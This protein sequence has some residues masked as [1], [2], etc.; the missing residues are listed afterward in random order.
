MKITVDI[1]SRLSD[2]SLQQ[3]QKYIELIETNKDNAEGENL[4]HF[5]ALKTLEIFCNIPYKT[6]MMLKVRDVNAAIY[7]ITEILA[8]KPPLRMKYTLGDST[9][10]LIPKLD[11]MSFGEYID[12]DKYI[13]NWKDM[14]KAMAVL[15]RPIDAMIGDQYTIQEYKGDNYWEAMKHMPLDVVFSSLLFFYHLGIE[16]SQ[17]TVN[18]LSRQESSKDWHT[19]LEKSGVTTSQFTTLVEET[20]GPMRI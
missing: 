9:F 7:K 8:H 19:T 3:Y 17:I 16:L 14:H 4:E 11:D 20:L 15:Y 18:Y 13:V 1:P 5:L 2:I 10:G 6:G 12:L